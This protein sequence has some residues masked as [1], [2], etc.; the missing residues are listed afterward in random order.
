MARYTVND[1]EKAWEIVL[2]GFEVSMYEDESEQYRRVW[3]SEDPT[4]DIKVV[5]DLIAAT[6]TLFVNGTATKQVEVW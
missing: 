3:L 1:I 4:P 2:E 5:E 6:V